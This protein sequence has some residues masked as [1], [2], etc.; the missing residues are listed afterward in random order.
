MA[1][2]LFRFPLTHN[3][4]FYWYGANEHIFASCVYIIAIWNNEIQ[5]GRRIGKKRLLLSKLNN[6]LYLLTTIW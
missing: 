6:K 1:L 3:G 5:N 4:P 2:I